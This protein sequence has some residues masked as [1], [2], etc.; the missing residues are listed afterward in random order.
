MVS[1]GDQHRR[2]SASPLTHSGG[3]HQ[4]EDA[5][6]GVQNVLAARAAVVWLPLQGQ[7][8]IG[9]VVAHLQP[10]LASVVIGVDAQSSG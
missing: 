9:P 7:V 4:L 3:R 1:S 6:L 10:R 2:D 5:A 8:D